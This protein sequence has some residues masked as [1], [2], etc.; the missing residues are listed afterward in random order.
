MCFVNS[1]SHKLFTGEMMRI[2]EAVWPGF[3]LANSADWLGR[4]PV[5]G[6]PSIER[7]AAH[8]ETS[9]TTHTNT[10]TYHSSYLFFLSCCSAVTQKFLNF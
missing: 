3:W 8:N 10:P 4:W 7:H 6:Q 1:H 5:P 2:D 9:R